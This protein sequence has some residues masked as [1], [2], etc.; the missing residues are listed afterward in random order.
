M[1]IIFYKLKQILNLI[2]NSHLI[3][4]R[5]TPDTPGSP[6]NL[7]ILEKETNYTRISWTAPANDG[8][9]GVIDYK[10]KIQ[11]NTSD[12]VAIVMPEILATEKLIGQLIPGSTYRVWVYARN[13]VGYS[14]PVDTEFTTQHEGIKIY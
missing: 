13:I 9:S 5:Y 14:K 1:I 3:L 10:V 7:R 11:Q 2:L 4:Y 6:R 8:G 12:A